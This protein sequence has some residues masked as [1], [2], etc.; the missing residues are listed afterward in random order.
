MSLVGCLTLLTY[1]ENCLSQEKAPNPSPIKVELR[2]GEPNSKLA[3]RY[4][5]KGRQFKLVPSNKS[6]LEGILPIETRLH[7]GSTPSDGFLAILTRP[8]ADKPYDRLYLDENNDGELNEPVIKCEPKI[9]RGSTWSSFDG[10]IL[11]NQG[12]SG[13]PTDF[14][15]FPIAL[16][17]V[18][19]DPAGDSRH[20][21]HFASWIFDRRSQAW[22]GNDATR[23]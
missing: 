18:V 6:K 14:L 19:E 20:D 9:V 3:P 13:K 11:V 22:R 10:K 5:P 15:P 12:A 16:W 17:I 2:V 1:H 7:L 21:S 4:S 8:A 23:H